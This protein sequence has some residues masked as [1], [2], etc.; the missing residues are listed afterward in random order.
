MEKA[1]ESNMAPDAAFDDKYSV[2]SNSLQEK[3]RH[4][5]IPSEA[6]TTQERHDAVDPNTEASMPPHTD[7]T[8]A[9]EVDVEKA[10]DAKPNP[11]MDPSSFPDGGREAWLVVLGAFCSL[12]VSFGWINCKCSTVSCHLVLRPLV[13]P[14]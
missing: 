12:F 13:Y 10:P 5:G 2:S 7:N 4:D 9:P 6:Q 8:T 1:Q 14:S 3:G 11:M